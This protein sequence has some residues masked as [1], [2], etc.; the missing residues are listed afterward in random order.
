MF[1]IGWKF[2]IAFEKTATIP[3]RH[4]LFV[5][6]G[7]RLL[8]L[9]LG[10]G[11]G[12]RHIC[13]LTESLGRLFISHCC[14]LLVH[15]ISTGGPGGGDWNIHVFSSAV[16]PLRGYLIVIYSLIYSFFIFIYSGV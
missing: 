13:V 9:F 10:G 5:C 16:F 4:H 14:H 6:L 2:D 3:T 8:L 7:G 11:G 1:K 12:R 15:S